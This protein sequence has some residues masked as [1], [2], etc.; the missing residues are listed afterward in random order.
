VLY[1]FGVGGFDGGYVGVDIFFVISGFLM[2]GIIYR[3]L[4]GE[5]S[6]KP[7]TFLW[8]FYLARGK[9]ILPAL[10]VL[11]A[12]LLVVGCF[13]LSAVEF[14][15]LGEQV[16]SAVLF[17]SNMKF[18][19]ETGYF[20]PSV[21]NIWLLHTWSLSVEWQFYM[22]LPVALLAIWKVRPTR[23]ALLVA[24]VLGAGLSLGVCLFE[25][26]LKP[27]TAFFLL[28]CRA[29]EMIAGGLVALAVR[30]P[31]RSPAVRRGLELLGLAMIT[32]SILTFG[33]LVWPNWRALVPV[34]GTMLVLIAARQSSPLTNW[35]PLQ[36]TGRCSYSMYL[37]HWPLATGLHYMERQHDPVAIACAVAL[38][39][40]LGHLS[41]VLVENRL[42]R[43]LERLSRGAAGAALAGACAAVV[44][45]AMLVGREDGFAQR[46]PAPVN[47]MFAAAKDHIGTGSCN[48]LEKGNDSGC[49]VGGDKLSVIV[50]G[51]SHADSAFSAVTRALPNASMGA[52]NWSM[53][54]C[55]SMT[56]MHSVR[57]DKLRCDAFMQWAL[58]RLR[59]IPA[60]VPVVVINRTSLY[61]EGPNEDGLEQDVAV[62]AFYFT[63]QYPKRTAAFYKEVS[64]RLIETACT[65]AK[66][67]TV[68]LLRPVPEMAVN[69]P[70]TMAR[71][72]I[73]GRARDIS[74]SLSEYKQRHRLV[75]EAQDAAR[76]RCGVKIL[77]PLPYLCKDGRCQA[78]IGGRPI[79]TDNNHLS[80]YGGGYLVP[81]FAQM[82]AGAPEA[83]PPQP[84]PRLAGTPKMPPP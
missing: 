72:M 5:A 10:V 20:T 65:V 32:W 77:D 34:A 64:E 47:A 82:F 45:P 28:P 25:A 16:T 68:Y 40:A 61:M 58:G 6:Q 74:L 49:L 44:L 39:F 29:W 31:P 53:A 71:A 22:V 54:G 37:W 36:W 18:W 24:L 78:L 15:A 62:P 17:F 26:R 33:H 7:G 41:Y 63:T 12:T 52:L 48:I 57:D 23:Q 76:E 11:C 1:H 35:A 80:T 73:T 42:R 9:R 83:I 50:I 4:Q 21:F 3:A 8:R 66:E 14:K 43:P 59:A 69:V 46:F 13:F 84:P 30:Q 55:P 38:T 60:D 56:G 79:Y 2:T 27:S 70:R 19:R 51:D 67:R 75:W 81:L